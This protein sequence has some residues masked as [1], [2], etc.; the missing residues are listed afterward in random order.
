MLRL[1]SCRAVVGPGR[2]ERVAPLIAVL[3][4]FPPAR[5]GLRIGIGACP[6]LYPKR[7]ALQLERLSKETFQVAPVGVRHAADR[8]AMDDDHRG[9][10]S[11]LVRVAQF[12][13]SEP[14]ARRVLPDERGLKRAGELGRRQ[15]C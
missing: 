5:G 4:A 10:V 7:R 11:A 13:S 9:I 1:F 14:G 8:V 12:G 3:A 6:E 15:P 2:L